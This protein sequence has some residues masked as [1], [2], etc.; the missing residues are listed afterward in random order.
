MPEQFPDDI[1][2]IYDPAETG[3]A[4]CLLPQLDDPPTDTDEPEE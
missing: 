1:E 2:A 4:G 3:F